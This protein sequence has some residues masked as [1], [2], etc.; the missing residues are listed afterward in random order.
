MFSAPLGTLVSTVAGQ[1]VY[2]L[3][4][5]TTPGFI[6]LNASSAVA[7]IDDA[8]D[9]QQ[10]ISFDGTPVTANNGPAS[11]E[12]STN[13]GSAGPGSS[14]E[15]NRDGTSYSTQSSPN[16]DTVPCYTPGTMIDTPDGPRAVET[17]RS[18]DFVLTADHGPQEIRWVRSGDHPLEEVEVDDKPVL[19]QAGALG[20]TGHWPGPSVAAVQPVEPA[21]RCTA[22]ISISSNSQSADEAAVGVSGA[23]DRSGSS[24]LRQAAISASAR[25]FLFGNFRILLDG[26]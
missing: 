26:V 1:D 25:L 20:P 9:T 3:D 12:T 23:N 11:G 13:V 19:I 10:F 15:S 24:S 16:K 4:Q 17:L 22:D 21:V 5:A 14:V 6:G 8:G 18:G 2:V 7:L